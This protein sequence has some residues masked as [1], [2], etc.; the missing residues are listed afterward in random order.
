L[1]FFVV[2]VRASRRTGTANG[3]DSITAPDLLAL[4][5]DEIIGHAAPGSIG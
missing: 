3:S 5:D 2:K 1:S 4:P